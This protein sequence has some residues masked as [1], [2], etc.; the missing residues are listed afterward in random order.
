M[1]KKIN[2]DRLKVF[3]E[4]ARIIPDEELSLLPRD[5]REAVS[6]KRGVWIEVAC[7]DGACS[8]DK[9]KI[10]LPA[11]G[12]IRVF[13]QV[14]EQTILLHRGVH[15][16]VLLFKAGV[17][18]SRKAGVGKGR[19]RRKQ[20]RAPEQETNQRETTKQSPVD[21]GRQMCG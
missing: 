11:G 13:L 16:S 19:L 10:T 14:A 1:E 2:Q 3:I 12:M 6:G 18:A 4:D 7:P 15:G 21:I 8:V 20:D 17:A 9:E 5:K